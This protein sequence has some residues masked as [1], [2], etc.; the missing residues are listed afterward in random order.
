MRPK[1]VLKE[2]VHEYIQKHK[3]VKTSKLATHFNCSTATIFRK[4]KG[5]NS[6]ASYNLDRQFLTLRDIP[7]FDNNG[8]WEYRGARFSK[9]GGVRPTLEYIV[10]KSGDGMSAGE[11]NKILYLRT[12]NQLGLCVKEGRIIRKRYGRF[13]I[14]FSPDKQAQESQMEKREK[15]T[16]IRVPVINKDKIIEILVTIIRSR[17]TNVEKLLPILQKEGV[18]VN[19]KSLRWV[20]AKYEIEKKGSP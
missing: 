20:F 6:L 2:A 16:P 12:N 7:L 10:S 8:L 13:Q 5:E 14:Y 19:Q 17:Q 1:E 15:R 9:Q 11:I 4:L 3:V 18:D